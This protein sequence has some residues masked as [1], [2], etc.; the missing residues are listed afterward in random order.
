M[1]SPTIDTRIIEGSDFLLIREDN[2]EADFSMN[3]HIHNSFELS[4][5]IDGDGVSQTYNQELMEIRE[6]KVKKNTILL[7]KGQIPH[8]SI[9]NSASPLKQV[10]IFFDL[11][12]LKKMKDYQLILNALEQQNP[13]VISNTLYNL[14]LKPLFREILNEIRVN[15]PGKDTLTFGLLSKLL[16]H[17]LRSTEGGH[18]FNA[19]SRDERINRTLEYINHNYYKNICIQDVSEVCALSLRQFSEVFKKEIGKTFVQYLNVIRIAKAKEELRNTNRSITD[20]AFGVGFDD[21]SYFTRRFKAQ[22]KI[23]PSQY[24]KNFL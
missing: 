8:R 22:E 2:H 9:D 13:L 20:I 14:Q 19:K 15:N 3:F 11:I 16:I 23:T 7:M 6:F 1:E 10:L 18:E 17:I 24:K 21:L 4:F 5:V 12:Y